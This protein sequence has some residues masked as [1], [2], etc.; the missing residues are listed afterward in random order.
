[1][2][3]CSALRDVYDANG[4]RAMRDR[5][6]TELITVPWLFCGD[7]TQS[8]EQKWDGIRR[9]GDEIVSKL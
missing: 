5:A 4:Y 6:V 3:A 2:S 8:C 1:M 7:D 9:F